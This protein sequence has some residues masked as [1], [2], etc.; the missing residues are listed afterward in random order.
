MSTQVQ[1]SQVAYDNLAENTTLRSPVTGV[2]TTRN[3]D[4]GDLYGSAGPI[5]IIMQIDRVKVQ[6]NISE[7]YFPEVKVGMPVDIKLDVYPGEVFQG[8]VSLI[9]P[10]V[11]ATTR[12]FTTEITIP[13]GDQK[14][15]PGMFCRVALNF[16][17]QEQDQVV[18]PDIG[19]QKQAGTNERF[20]FVV[21]NGKAI[22]RTV[23]PG[24]QVGSDVVILSGIN[25]G[26][27]VVIA[28]GQKLL[29]G[30]EVD[31]TRE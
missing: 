9:H 22:R 27:N 1:A 29:D 20:S 21:E 2:V 16:G 3:Y 30:I 17:E 8:K 4:P 31:V 11:D 5:L 6:V 10:S 15:R 28:G 13:N 24:R 19:I 7:A 25:A 18:I 12:T 23:V 26:E 14:L